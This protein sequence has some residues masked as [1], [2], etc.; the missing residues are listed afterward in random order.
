MAEIALSN[1]L[2]ALVDDAD[3]P[4]LS[5]WKWA[6]RQTREGRWYAMRLPRIPGTLTKRRVVHMHRF[7]AGALQGEIIDHINNSSLDNRRSNLRRATKQQNAINCKIY[8]NNTSGFKGVSWFA[9]SNLSFG[10]YWRAQ[11]GRKHLG[12]FKNKEAAADA[13]KKAAIAMHGEFVRV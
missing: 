8:S 11:V 10:G 13:Y 12:Y 5:K 9:N 1:G 2:K 7:L 3:V 4:M 6:A